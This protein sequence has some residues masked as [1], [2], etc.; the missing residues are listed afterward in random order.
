MDIKGWWHSGH[1]GRSLNFVK[2]GG[3]EEAVSE[4]I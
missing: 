2:F 3:K 1:L 4:P